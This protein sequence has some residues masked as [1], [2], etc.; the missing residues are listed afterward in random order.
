MSETV[1]DV[2]NKSLGRAA[3]EIALILQGKDKASYEQRKIGGNIVRV[4]NISGLK[5]TGRK[6]EQKTYYR[7]TGFMGHLKSKTLEEA[8]AKSPE[9]VLRHAVR[10]MLPKNSLLPKRLKLLVIDK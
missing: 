4:K 7:H 2:K 5:F 6:L 10:G 9:W 1:M 3:T 8:F